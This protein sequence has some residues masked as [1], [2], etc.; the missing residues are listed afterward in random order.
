[1]PERDP[2]EFVQHVTLDLFL[3]LQTHFS[4]AANARCW[5]AQRAENPR[6]H[7]LL[8]QAGILAGLEAMLSDPALTDESLYLLS[9]IVANMAKQRPSLEHM[10]RTALEYPVQGLLK[11]LSLS[12]DS[13]TEMRYDSVV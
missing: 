10:V 13:K 4:A 12:N 6:M 11:R 2:D 7:E 3:L 1:M 5:F 9:L 8:M